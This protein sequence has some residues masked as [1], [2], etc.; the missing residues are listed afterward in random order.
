MI[1]FIPLQNSESDN[2]SIFMNKVI[3]ICVLLVVNLFIL[4]VL[5]QNKADSPIMTKK[6]G[7]TVLTLPSGSGRAFLPTPSDNSEIVYVM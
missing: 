7:V 1:Y 5:S 2:I 4:N 6:N 3:S